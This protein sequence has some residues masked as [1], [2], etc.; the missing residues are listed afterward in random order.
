MA[1][2]Q[3][4]TES[5]RILDLMINSIYTHK[6]IFLRELISNASDAIDKYYFTNQGHVNSDE[7]EIRID[8]DEENRKITI[9]DT[10]IGMDETDLDENLGTIAQ[11]GSL[12][13]KEEM[14][15]E[16]KKEEDIDIIGQFGVGFYSAFMVSKEITV[17][18]KK[19]GCPAYK[20]TSDGVSGYEI[21][22]GERENHGTTIILTLKEDSDEE[23]YSQY[24]KTYKIKDL[25]KKYSDYIRYPIHMNVETT[26]VKEGSEDK[27]NPEYET[28]IE[29][30]TLNSMVPLW[31]RAKSQITQEEYNQFYK[32]HFYDYSDPFRTIHFNVEGNVSFNAL[33]YIPS[34]VPQG[35]YNADY[36]R[37]LQLYCRGVFIMDH[38]EDLLPDYLRFVKGLV[39]SQDLSLN[40]SRELLQHDHQ[41]KIIASRIEKKVLSELTNLLT[42]EREE[43]EKFWNNFGINLKFGCYNNY[44][45][46]KDKLQDLLLFN[47][48]KEN[49]LVTLNEYVQRMKEDQKDIY[50]VS[51]SDVNLIDKLPVVQTLKSKGFE[52]LYL[53]DNVD[54]FVMQSLMTYREKG[55]KNAAQGDL[56]IDSQEEKDELNKTKEENKELLDFMKD[57][58]EEV[59]E[60][61]LS[62]K[63]IDDPVC[64]TAGE[65]ISFEMERVFNN[66]PD[67]PMP[68]KANRILEINPKHPIFERLKDLY[69][70]DKDKVKEVAE[71]LYDQACLI[72][73]F[74]IKDPIA[75]S[76]KICE[77]LVK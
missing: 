68:M 20:W 23:D 16:D 3:F 44:G 10:G 24:L 65:G 11:S 2:K 41:L 74:P 8:L 42:K 47:S 43:Y 36:K 26:K 61:R 55:F 75:Y 32:D 76:R 66:M 69:T 37:G 59:S 49:K 51:G 30:Q 5:K 54:E 64:L 1:Q 53:T 6:E 48:S 33:L 40:I 17:I 18:S 72:E 22:E 14:A 34:R 7:L 63:L 67:N 39:D 4:K 45:R 70:D 29:E 12:A 9:S 15:K 27:D 19:E 38:A 73:G 77:L 31:K 50:Y 46:D 71:V 60:V 62:S 21:S 57:S 28:V 25:V 52:V 58:L 35:F 13:F 56:D